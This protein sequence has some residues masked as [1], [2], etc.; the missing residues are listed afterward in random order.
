MSVICKGTLHATAGHSSIP[1]LAKG[2]A[3][4]RQGEYSTHASFAR[5]FNERLER[6]L[7]LALVMLGHIGLLIVM[8]RPAT[9]FRTSDNK[10]WIDDD[11]WMQL[12]IIRAPERHAATAI[13][14][15]TPVIHTHTRSAPR[16]AHAAPEVQA[17]P[18]QTSHAD[19]PV[20]YLAPAATGSYIAG[21]AG[22]QQRLQASDQTQ[23]PTVPG[24]ADVHGAP[25]F[26]MMEERSIGARLVHI[27]GYL[28]GAVNSHCVDANTWQSMTPQQLIAAHVSQ[29]DI[30]RAI[31]QNNCVEPERFKN[32][33]H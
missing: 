19:T 8:L 4:M 12:R 17:P 23:I 1:N 31:A 24:D 16:I 13:P 2:F 29:S 27:I 26:K 9:P 15:P 22:F 11:T 14:A 18:E 20:L 30:Q 5:R 33:T 6:P 21:G 28:G 3:P 10:R 7:L 32:A 25:R